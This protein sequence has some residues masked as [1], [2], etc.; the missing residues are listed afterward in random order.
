MIPLLSVVMQFSDFRNLTTW[1][2]SRN[3][4]TAFL[5]FFFFIMML[6]ELWQATASLSNFISCSAPS[7]MQF[8]NRTL[9]WAF[10]ESHPP[11]V[12][13]SPLRDHPTVPPT[14][15]RLLL[16]SNQ[17][18]PPTVYIY[19]YVHLV[20]KTNT[21]GNVKKSIFAAFWMR[22]LS[23]RSGTTHRN[24]SQ[25]ARQPPPSLIHIQWQKIVFSA[26]TDNTASQQKRQCF[27]Y[28]NNFQLKFYAPITRTVNLSAGAG[29]V[30][31]RSKAE[32]II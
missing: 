13:I 21:I 29:G 6:F 14:C 16:R 26:H 15:I 28:R 5:L 23:G 3:N 22:L 32:D 25:P 20:M 8:P 2:W 10:R 7:G 11:S 17:T 1:K 9:N 18:A 31:V 24:A 30:W 19:M 4:I 12:F 27:A